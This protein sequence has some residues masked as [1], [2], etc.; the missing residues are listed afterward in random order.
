M[1]GVFPDYAAPI[2]PN[3]PEGRELALVR[4]G[5]PT[6]TKYLV[7]KKTDPG[8]TNIRNVN[9]A[10]WRRWLGVDSG[11]RARL[12]CIFGSAATGPPT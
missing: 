12:K 3:Q 2:V 9:S 11:G 4:W 1:S 8:V 7:G 6:P 5:M 10:H